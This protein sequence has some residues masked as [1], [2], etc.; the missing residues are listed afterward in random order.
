MAFA[1]S[2]D[3]FSGAGIAVGMRGENA[4]TAR[5]IAAQGDNVTH[6][7]LPIG[8]G[9]FVY[10]RPAG[11]DAG[12][13]RRGRDAGF[14]GDPRD[15]IMCAFPGSATRTIGHRHKTRCQWLQGQYR[16]PQLL[17]HFLGFGREK[18]KA[19]LCV[20]RQACE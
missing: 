6:A 3:Q 15:R 5:R 19:N 10:F 12:Q 9:D 18:F 20:A 7:C 16:I 2:F 1:Q 14:L 8:I 11:I 4:V 17:L 13:M